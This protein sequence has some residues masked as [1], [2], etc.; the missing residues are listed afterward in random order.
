M[1]DGR[2][3]QDAVA[4]VEDVGP[5][6]PWPPAAASTRAI[7][8]RAAGAQQQGSSAPWMALLPPGCAGRAPADGRVSSATAWTG[9]WSHSS[10]TSAAA[11]RGKPMNGA[12]DAERRGPCRRCAWCGFDH[13]ALEQSSARPSAQL[14]KSFSTWAPASGLHHQIAGGGL[15]QDV[16]QGVELLGIAHRRRCGPRRA[17]CPGPRSY[18]WPPSTARRRSRSGPAPAPVRR[19]P[20]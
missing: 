9:T 14:S 2:V 5:A 1:G 12:V 20:G 15:D 18:R 8:R 3:R 13:Q 10:P 4:E 17:R 6:A 16:Q 7:Q 11:P 19:A